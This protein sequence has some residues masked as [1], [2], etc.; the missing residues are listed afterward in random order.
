MHL[1]SHMVALVPCSIVWEKLQA[2]CL[3]WCM[4]ITAH[5]ILRL[6]WKIKKLS[7]FWKIKK[8]NNRVTDMTCE[9]IYDSDCYIKAGI[10]T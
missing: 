6:S 3:E 2:T 5:R 1:E 8:P 7:L 4:E 9:L 10:F